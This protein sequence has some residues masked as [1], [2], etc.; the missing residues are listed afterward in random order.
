[1]GDMAKLVVKGAVANGT[2][3]GDRAVWEKMAGQPSR[4]STL[5]PTAPAPSRSVLAPAPPAETPSTASREIGA[6]DEEATRRAAE[7]RRSSL[8]VGN[9]ETLGGRP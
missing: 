5:E 4:A 7:R 6:D 1:M 8:V 9:E 3:T 2:Y